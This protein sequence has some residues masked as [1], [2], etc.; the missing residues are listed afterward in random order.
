[1]KFFK[2]SSTNCKMVYYSKINKISNTFVLV[3]GGYVT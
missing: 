2:A 1:M 3:S